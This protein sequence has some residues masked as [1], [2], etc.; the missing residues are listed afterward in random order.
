[1]RGHLLVEP[2]KDG[3]SII[4]ASDLE[5]N[6]Q[7][8]DYK[9]EKADKRANKAAR[10]TPFQYGMC[11]GWSVPGT[12]TVREYLYNMQY[13]YTPVKNRPDFEEWK[14]SWK[15]RDMTRHSPMQENDDDCG[16]FTIL[17][18]YLIS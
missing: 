16:V 3:V 11:Q 10:Y 17:S 7:Q 18:I 13:R 5:D 15:M 4:L 2:P 6:L 1:M 8:I 14:L 12:M 9:E